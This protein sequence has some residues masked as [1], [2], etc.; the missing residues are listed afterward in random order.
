MLPGKFKNAI[1]S[2]YEEEM[3][4]KTTQFWIGANMSLYP[5][6]VRHVLEIRQSLD[7]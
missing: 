7:H 5:L 2:E 4:D 1:T 6:N 3:R